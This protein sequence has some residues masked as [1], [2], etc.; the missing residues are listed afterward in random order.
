[1][2]DPSKAEN[3]QRLIAEYR[4][5]LSKAGLDS[6]CP[7]TCQALARALPLTHARTSEQF[8]KIA[9]D[10]K[11]IGQK[12]LSPAKV[13]EHFGIAVRSESAEIAL[14]THEFV[15]LYCGQFRYPTTQV[16][17]L[18]STKLEEEF[19]DV[20]EASPFDSGALHKHTIWGNPKESAQDFLGRHSLPVPGYRE[21][22]AQ[23]LHYL[24]TAPGDYL[25]SNK[26]LARSDPIGLRPK[27]PLTTSDSRLWTFEV[28]LHDEVNLRW[29]HLEAIF[30]SSRLERYPDVEAFLADQNESVHLEPILSDEEDLLFALQNR[31]LAYLRRC[32]II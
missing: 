13:A 23:R 6:A 26:P 24:F 22:L 7:S 18:F 9:A 1:M 4:A 14:N 17:L 29:P 11:R 27:P 5:H 15:F 28:R 19:Q 31:C 10:E 8:V 16:G 12:L 30:Y 3:L 2:A 32:S 25:A 21:F 20:S